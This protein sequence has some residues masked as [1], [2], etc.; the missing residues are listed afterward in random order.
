[1]LTRFAT[2]SMQMLESDVVRLCA[3]SIILAVFVGYETP[4]EATATR[5]LKSTK[6]AHP[7]IYKVLNTS[8]R[9]WLYQRTET[10]KF[11]EPKYAPNVMFTET[12]I[13]IKKINISE[14]KYHFWEKMDV[15]GQAISNHYIGMF[16]L[17][18][19]GPPSSMDVSDLSAK[20]RNPFLRMTLKYTGQG[21]SIFEVFRLGKS[22]K[23]E[24]NRRPKCEMYIRNHNG[25]ISPPEDC[26]N[27]YETHCRRHVHTPYSSSCLT[28]TES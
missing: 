17:K 22:D 11:T 14:T 23:K 13:F 3:F 24:S 20:N 26:T 15:N 2:S 27:F 19:P 7:N 21:C 6:G 10:N 25:R 8:R 18:P 16:D 5:N 4:A 12:C 1:M 9:L 28:P